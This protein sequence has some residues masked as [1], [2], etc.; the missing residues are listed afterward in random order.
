MAVVGQWEREVEQEAQ[1]TIP[2]P[3]PGLGAGVW[4]TKHIGHRGSIGGG[5]Y[6]YGGSLRDAAIHDELDGDLR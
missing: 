4:V 6:I 1:R 2:E 5:R 3:G